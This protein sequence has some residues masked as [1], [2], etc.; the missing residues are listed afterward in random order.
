MQTTKLP[1]T[2]VIMAGGKEDAGGQDQSK[3]DG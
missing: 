3:K 1:L 2:A